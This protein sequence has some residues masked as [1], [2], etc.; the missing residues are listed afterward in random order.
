MKTTQ[1]QKMTGTQY[2][3]FGVVS[4]SIS[5]VFSTFLQFILFKDD[6]AKNSKAV[7]YVETHPVLS[8]TYVNDPEI[9]KKFAIGLSQV[10]TITTMPDFSETPFITDMPDFS[11]LK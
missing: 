8:P 3:L 1:E 7:T 9:A 11:L 6:V 4:F 5:L 10:P 2:L